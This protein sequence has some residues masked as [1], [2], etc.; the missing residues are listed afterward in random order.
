MLFRSVE[1]AELGLT[2]DVPIYEG[3]L[4]RSRIREAESRVEIEEVRIRQAADLVVRRYGALLEAAR[5]SEART[6]AIARQLSRAEEELAGTRAAGDAGRADAQV[7]LEQ[8]LRR[9]TLS[10]DLQ[11]SRLRTLRIQAELLTLFGALDM[12]ALSRQLN[13]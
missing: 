10:V 12:D 4:V 5:Q 8:Q 3:G 13:S 1:S 11:A 6:G 7:L 2:L 9:D